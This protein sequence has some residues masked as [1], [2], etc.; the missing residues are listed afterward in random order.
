V[1]EVVIKEIVRAAGED[2]SPGQMAI[3]NVVA[4]DVVMYGIAIVGVVRMN[5]IPRVVVDSIAV[6]DVPRTR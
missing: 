2:D 6:Y 1:N 5:A 3:D 4:N